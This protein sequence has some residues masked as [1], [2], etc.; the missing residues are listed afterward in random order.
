MRKQKQ[1]DDMTEE[2]GR[3]KR[4]NDHLNQNI[5]VTEDAYAK[6]EEQTM[7]LGHK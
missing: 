7:S 1:I 4:E 3:L 6:M 2:A 5:K